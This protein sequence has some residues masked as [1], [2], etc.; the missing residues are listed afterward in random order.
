MQDCVFVW[1]RK[2]SFTDLDGWRK[3]E[4]MYTCMRLCNVLFMNWVYYVLGPIIM[5]IGSGIVL[6]F[7]ISVRP[8]GLPPFI[9]YWIPFIAF[10]TFLVLSWLWYDVVTM[11]REGEDMVEILQSRSHRFLRELE[12][13]QRQF[14][15]RK[16]RALRPPYL[17]IGQFSDMTLEG[18]VGVW[19]E[20]LNQF[21]FLLSL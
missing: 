20:I 14:V 1:H 9:Y 17:T 10:G 13:H 19:D 4:K 2:M 16:G 5:G 12:P 18:L 7:Y 8:S 6:L 15:Y 3:V 11:K 21:L